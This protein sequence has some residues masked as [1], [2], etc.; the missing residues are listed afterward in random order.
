MFLWKRH[1]YAPD[2]E[3]FIHIMNA[4][5]SLGGDLMQQDIPNNFLRLLAD[6]KTVYSEPF[7]S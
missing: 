6:G 4:V 7:L 1:T 5:F 3:W 2:N